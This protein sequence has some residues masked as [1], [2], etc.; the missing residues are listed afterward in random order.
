MPPFAKAAGGANVR[1][2]PAERD[3]QPNLNHFPRKTEAR[4]RLAVVLAVPAAWISPSTS[5]STNPRNG[6]R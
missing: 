6:R 4:V 3:G 5:G 1:D 2:L